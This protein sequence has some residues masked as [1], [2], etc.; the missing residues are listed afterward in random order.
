MFRSVATRVALLRRTSGARPAFQATLSKTAPAVILRSAATYSKILDKVLGIDVR[1]KTK[2]VPTKEVDPMYLK[3]TILPPTHGVQICRVAFRSFQLHRMDFYMDFCRKAAFNMG[4]PCTGTVCLPRVIRRWTVL[5]SPFV[6]K[7]SMEVFERRTHKR[8]LVVRDADPEVVKKW[9]A[10]I[11]KNMPAGL[12][13]KYWMTEHEPMDIGAQIEN[14]LKTGDTRQIDAGAISNTKYVEKLV[15]RGRRR[16]WTTYKDLPVYGRADVE[17]LAMDIAGK[18][19]VNPRANIEEIT[20]DAVMGSRPP[21][22]PKKSK[23]AAENTA[24]AAAPAPTAPESTS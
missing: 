2:M 12:G 10:Y 20:R 8:L 7:S 11:N 3:P 13:M 14:A 19:K 21:S 24:D 18:L 22:P 23:K 9:L 17:K 15:E 1:E 4:I 16:M 6:H 5:K